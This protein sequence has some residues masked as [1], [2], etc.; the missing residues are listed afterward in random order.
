[1]RQGLVQL[2]SASTVLKSLATFVRKPGT[3]SLSFLILK[4]MRFAAT[5]W[6]MQAQEKMAGTL[7]GRPSFCWIHPAPC[8]G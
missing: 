2:P 5:T 1:M 6:F 4:R 7:R 3:P 8:V